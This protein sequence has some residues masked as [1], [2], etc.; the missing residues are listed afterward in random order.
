ML[1]KNT[2][3]LI[4]TIVIAHAV[5]WTPPSRAKEL[6]WWQNAVVYQIYPRSFKVITAYSTTAIKRLSYE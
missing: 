3:F 4:F 1:L 6:D 5:S 2:L